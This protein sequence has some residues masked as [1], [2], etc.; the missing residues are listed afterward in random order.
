MAERV[1]FG[2]EIICRNGEFTVVFAERIKS[3]LFLALAA[4]VSLIAVSCSSVAAPKRLYVDSAFLTEISW[5]WGDGEYRA[6]V[7]A[8]YPSE[9]GERE[10]RM[11]FLS[12]EEIK[13]ISVSLEGE[14]IFVEM[15]G[16]SAEIYDRSAIKYAL[17]L[18]MPGSFT[19]K[20]KTEIDG[21][22]LIVSQRIAENTVCDI[23]LD[24]QTGA[25]VKICGG[26]E[27]IDIIWFEYK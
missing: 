10:L 12:P 17:L 13:G 4:V 23:Y 22:E 24:P 26:G 3:R 25:P 6:L 9:D 8:K 21:R 19:Y 5:R 14:R 15:G 7:D 20:G 16:V 27:S 1:S 18:C 11:E 2:H